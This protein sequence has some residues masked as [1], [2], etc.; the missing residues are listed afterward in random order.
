MPFLVLTRKGFDDLVNDLGR[1][2][3]PIWVN[4]GVLSSAEIEEIRSS[5]VEL[6]NFAHHISP[7]DANGVADAVAT[8]EQ[9]HVGKS[10]W[11]EQQS[12]V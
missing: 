2:P 6:T 3:S 7:M 9:H 11:R 10:V 4:D 5:G 8:I 1:I 12:D